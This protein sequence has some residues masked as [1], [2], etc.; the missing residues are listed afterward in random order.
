MLH[1]LPSTELVALLLS[2]RLVNFFVYRG[3]DSTFRGCLVSG[4][5]SF[6]RLSGK[7]APDVSQT[8]TADTMP[9]S[10]LDQ[11]ET[12]DFIVVRRSTAGRSG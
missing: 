5:T 10:S 2:L 3:D 8:P 1:Q 9:G 6:S 7:V 11:V 12:R 4:V